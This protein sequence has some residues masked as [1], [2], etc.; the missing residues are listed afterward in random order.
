PAVAHRMASDG[1][2]ATAHGDQHVV[3]ARV[4]NG[5]QDI[6]GTS[7][8]RD[9]RRPAVDRPVPD[10]SCLVVA[11]LAL[12]EQRTAEAAAEPVDS[13][14]LTGRCNRRR[15]QDPPSPRSVWARWA[16]PAI[17]SVR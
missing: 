5:L 3:L 8:A 9:Q 16:A 15:H 6:I 2:A 12:P 14:G 11:F 17:A 13:R 1:V 7:A 4:A 10:S